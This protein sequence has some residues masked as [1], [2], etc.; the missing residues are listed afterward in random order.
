M[1]NNLNP[2][3]IDAY[4]YDQIYVKSKNS[5]YITIQKNNKFV[6]KYIEKTSNNSRQNILKNIWSE[7]LDQP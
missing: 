5:T 2:E 7:P 1:T 4:I 6:K 3:N